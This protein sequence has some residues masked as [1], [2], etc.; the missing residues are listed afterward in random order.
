MTLLNGFWK[1]TT[2]NK[3]EL[4]F[5]S[6]NT[7]EMSIIFYKGVIGEMITTPIIKKNQAINFSEII[8]SDIYFNYEIDQ[9][10]YSV[11]L[12]NDNFKR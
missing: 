6:K 2:I 11:K 12:N 8:I 1:K 3:P 5:K 9:K 7:E 10:K 4:I